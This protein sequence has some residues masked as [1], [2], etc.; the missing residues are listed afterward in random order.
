MGNTKDIKPERNDHKCWDKVTYVAQFEKVT[1]VN[2]VAESED[3]N[4]GKV[5]SEIT[6]D[7]YTGSQYNVTTKD[8]I[9]IIT[10]TDLLDPTKSQQ[11]IAAGE[12]KYMFDHWVYTDDKGVEH[13]V[14]TD[15]YIV[16]NMKFKA[17]F[18]SNEEVTINISISEDALL[19]D[20]GWFKYNGGKAITDITLERVDSTQ[21]TLD[22]LEALVNEENMFDYKFA[23]WEFDFKD[24]L[25]VQV[26]DA[27]FTPNLTALGKAHWTDGMTITCY[28][29]AP[30]AIYTSEDATMRFVYDTAYYPSGDDGQI[31]FP[32][33]PDSY[34]DPDDKSQ[35]KFPA[36]VYGDGVPIVFPRNI[37]FETSFKGYTELTST[38]Y[39]F[40]SQLSYRQGKKASRLDGLSDGDLT[41]A[42]VLKGDTQPRVIQNVEGLENVYTENLADTSFMFASRNRN[43]LPLESLDFSS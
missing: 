30:K 34:Y 26:T 36:W 41:L 7:I 32:V 42:E 27:K 17:Y 19:G 15:G 28:F 23:Y 6:K 35:S 31:V 24:G 25:P 16:G 22:E 14:G 20:Q 12:G 10:I 21:T 11:I 2:I 9:S 18:Y 37:I 13:P 43:D 33:I 3:E 29:I 4:R 8:Q 39:W 1:K 5:T 38:S 40:S